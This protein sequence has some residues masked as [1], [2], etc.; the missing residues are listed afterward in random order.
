MTEK[1]EAIYRGGVFMPTR[2]LDLR[3]EERVRLTVETIDELERESRRRRC[4]AEGGNREHG[5]RLAKTA[6]QARRSASLKMI[7]ADVLSVRQH[8]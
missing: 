3:D 7:A 5:F 8:V 4:T 1:V 2:V 6:S